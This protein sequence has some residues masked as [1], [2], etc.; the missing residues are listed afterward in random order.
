[1][2]RSAEVA[3]SLMK[4]P[5]IDECCTDHSSGVEALLDTAQFAPSFAR[6]LQERERKVIDLAEWRMV[7]GLDVFFFLK[8]GL[9]NLGGN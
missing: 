9:M 3:Y 7:I 4:S 1:M 6:I 5:T 2:L 8:V